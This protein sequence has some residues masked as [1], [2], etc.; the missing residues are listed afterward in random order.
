MYFNIKNTLK[1]N[2]IPKQTEPASV[3]QHLLIASSFYSLFYFFVNFTPL[4]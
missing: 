3:D 4:S 2:H 1:N